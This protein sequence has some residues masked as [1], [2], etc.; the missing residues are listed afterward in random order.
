ML[1]G[2]LTAVI[3]PMKAGTIDMDRLKPY[4]KWQIEE[5]VDALVIGTATGE[6]HNLSYDELSSVIECAKNCADDKAYVVA[7]IHEASLD[8]ALAKVE[9]AE[10][11]GADILLVAPLSHIP[12]GDA[13]Q[14]AYY[15]AV[16]QLTT[17]PVFLYNDPYR[18]GVDVT[19]PLI[20]AILAETDNVHGIID[21]SGDLSRSAFIRDAGGAGFWYL[22]GDDTT[23]LAALAMGAVGIL[24]STSNI[25]PGPMVDMFNLAKEDEFAQA[26]QYHD[27]LMPLHWVLRSEVMP[28]PVKFAAYL[29]GI[30]EEESRPPL[31]ELEKETKSLIAGAITQTGLEPVNF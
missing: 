9:I 13:G 16:S 2:I 28:M 11:A 25:A 23:S 3:T 6:G 18:F 14:V 22:S 8:Q 17:N 10:K 31:T 29:L 19:V 4:L 12:P 26:L 24:S 15:K 30:C 5:G 7:T 27:A 1:K 21:A 20:Q